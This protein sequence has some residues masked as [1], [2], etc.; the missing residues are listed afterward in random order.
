MLLL[1]LIYDLCL[2]FIGLI[3]LPKFIYELIFKGKYR[4]SLLKRFGSSFPLIKKGDRPLVWIHAV[5]LGETKAVSAL[6]KKIRSEL[7]HPI[8][9]FSTTT[10]TGYVEACRSITADY[11]VY[12]PFDFR[13]IIRP[14]IRRTAPD[15]L[16]LCESDFWYNFISAAKKS[17]AHVVLVN[18][19]ISTTSLE[20]FKKVPF[21][22]KSLFHYVDL[23]CVQSHLYRQRFEELGIPPEK[24]EVT[25]NMK[26]DGDYQ[27]L[28]ASQ[29][30][31]WRRE[32]GINTEDPVIVVGS[33]HNP[34]ESLLLKVMSEVWQKYPNVKVMIVPRHPERFNEVAGILQKNNINYRRLS[35]KKRDD[36]LGMPVI[37][38]DAMGLLR[39]C[40]Q[41]A[42]I[43][44]V[45]GSYTSKVGGHNILEPSW[46]GVPVLFGPHM[47]SQPDLL[48]LVKEYRAGM[49]VS[50]EELPGVLLNLLGQ[51]N[52]C[53]LLGQAGLRLAGDIHGATGK[54]W[55]LIK[56][57]KI[58][59]KKKRFE[60]V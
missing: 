32:L 48:E 39:K 53:K 9:V 27:K 3:A 43:A 8:I 47:H 54:T 50:L 12:L 55:D 36:K 10:E 51:P 1:S 60:S 13:W 29:L 7:H 19:K 2:I 31:A 33:S 17:G 18:G 56:R 37:L 52:E 25:G 6:V 41:M 42:D 24:I 4:K 45:A 35:Q 34:E 40:Y 16:I 49:Q 20:R 59:R 26:F 46:Y 57:Y 14:I 23:L 22:T 5:S 21:F 58:A 11:H 38:I 30:V 15:L 28:P 44:I